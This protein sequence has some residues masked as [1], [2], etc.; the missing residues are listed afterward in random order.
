MIVARIVSTS[1]L[2]LF[3]DKEDEMSELGVVVI[4]QVI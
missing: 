2:S 4:G 1:S 3:L